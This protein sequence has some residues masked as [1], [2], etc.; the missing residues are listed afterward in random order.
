LDPQRERAP[1]SEQPHDTS[2]A[3]LEET[4]R[5]IA[6]SRGYVSNLMRT[7]AHAPDG[8]NPFAALGQYCRYGTQLTERQR[9][10]VIL[11]TLRDVRYGWQHHAPLG[12]AAGLTEEQVLLIREGRT[13]RDLD[14]LDHVLCE[15]AFEIIACRHVPPRIELEVHAHFKPRQIVDIAL[16]TSYYMATAAL[17]IALD[18]QIEGPDVLLLEQAWQARQVLPAA[19]E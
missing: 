10:I 11:A 12:R 2:D 15:F 4:F 9:E 8:L 13:P 19:D 18:V 16:L 17:I 5:Q 14:P 7:I 1:I 3:K 6:A